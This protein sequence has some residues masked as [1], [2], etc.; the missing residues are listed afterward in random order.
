[1]LWKCFQCLAC[2]ELFYSE[3]QIEIHQRIY[4]N[5]ECDR[6]DYIKSDEDNSEILEDCDICEEL[7]K[8]KDELSNHK[9][10]EHTTKNTIRPN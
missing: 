8:S 3:D 9:D 1:M 10:K 2:N 6:Y 5:K 4:P 7:F